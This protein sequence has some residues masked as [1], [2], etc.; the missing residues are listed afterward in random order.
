MRS[1]WRQA[2]WD[3]RPW[4]FLT[5][6]LR[7]SPL[8]NIVSVLRIALIACYWKFFLC[9]THK[10]SVSRGFA[11]QIMP[12]L[13]ILFYNSSLVTWT[14]VSLSTLHFLCLASP[15]RI[16]RTCS[17]SWFC[18]DF[19]LSPAQFYYI[20]VYKRKIESYMSIADWCAPWKISS[21]GQNLVLH[22]LQL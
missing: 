3:T 17:F 4:V 19:C 10:S 9:T 6:P 12:I 15:C 2:A 21:G 5:E 22:A 16:P 18:Y 13:H 20:I 11:K 7:Q 14:V 1:S 8:C